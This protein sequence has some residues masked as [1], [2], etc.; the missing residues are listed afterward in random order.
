MGTKSVSTASGRLSILSLALLLLA[1]TALAHGG[2]ETV[3]HSFG[4]RHDGQNPASTLIFD[5]AGNLYGTTAAGGT[6]GFGTVFKLTPNSGGFTESVVYSFRGSAN[7]DGAFPQGALTA[8]A[9]G[10]FFGVTSVG[11]HNNCGTVFKLTSGA[12]GSWSESILYAFCATGKTSD[13]YYPTGKLIFDSSG[14][15]YG[16][17]A[18]GGAYNGGV[19]FELAPSGGAWTETDL[20]SFP[21]DGRRDGSEPV[22]I[23]FDSAGNIDGVTSYGGTLFYVGSGVVFQLA[24]NPPGHWTEKVVHRFSITGANSQR[25]TGGLVFDGVGNLYMT[26]MGTSGRGGEG[27]FELSPGSGGT[28]TGRTLF[29][30]EQGSGQSYQELVFDSKGNLYSASTTGGGNC[31]DGGCGFVYKLSPGS[32]RWT[33]TKLA[34]FHGWDG[35]RP[36]GGVTMDGKGNLYG[37]TFTRN[38][39]LSG[40]GLVFQI[41]P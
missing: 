1:A 40:V 12:G 35:A 33:G 34:T 32:P 4:S 38:P 25:P 29:F 15:L 23:I 8:D 3:L 16:V 37:V 36:I 27:V 20:Y 17:T 41:T 24:Q 39:G 26:T 19:V 13:G 6:A 18:A 28:F 10:N 2:T 22:G 30:F 7:D 21:R 14:N 31:E 11:G 9:A 5:T